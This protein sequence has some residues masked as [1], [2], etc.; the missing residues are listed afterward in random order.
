MRLMARV[1]RYSTAV[2][3]SLTKRPSEVFS[4]WNVQGMKGVDPAGLLLEIA[5]QLQ[6]VHALIQGFP[7][8]EHHGGGGAHAQMVGRAVNVQ[9]FLGA[10]LETADAGGHAVDQDFGAAAGNGIQAG[11]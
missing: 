10:A 5:H 9:P 2:A 6:M 7:A 4:R 1:C 11:I 3:S 8:A